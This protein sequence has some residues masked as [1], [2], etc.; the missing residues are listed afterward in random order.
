MQKVAVGTVNKSVA[1][2][3]LLWFSKKVRHVC[4]VG[5]FR[6]ALD[7]KL[8]VIGTIEL[9]PCGPVETPDD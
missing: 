9:T 2:T 4:D 1:M 8:V 6:T 7:L 5:T 3:S